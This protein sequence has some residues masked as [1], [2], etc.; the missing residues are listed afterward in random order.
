MSLLPVKLVRP[1]GDITARTS[2]QPAS[3]G[4]FQGDSKSDRN[5]RERAK[6]TRGNPASGS[7]D[8]RRRRDSGR[9]S[10][11]AAHRRPADPR[12]VSRGC[13][14]FQLR[15]RKRRK[16]H[17]GSA[18]TRPHAASMTARGHGDAQSARAN[19]DEP[20][21]SFAKAGD[22]ASPRLSR[23]GIYLADFHAVTTTIAN[24]LG[25]VLPVIN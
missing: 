23:E 17:T 8:R 5:H 10:E 2:M 14:H 9:R 22:V 19:V 25:I 24:R 15:R 21:C 7:A 12:T 11:P 3:Y 4:C 6:G 16:P 1:T 13:F 20:A 18:L